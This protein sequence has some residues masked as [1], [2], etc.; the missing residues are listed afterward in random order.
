[1]LSPTTLDS[2]DLSIT[3]V[4]KKPRPELLAPAGEWEALKAAVANGAD[5][6][7][8]GLSDFNARH[9][10]TNFSV[11]ELPTVMRYLHDHNVRGYVTCNTLIFSDELPQ[12]AEYVKSLAQAGVD[13]VI[14]QD[15]GLVRLIRRL[16]PGLTVHGSTQMTLS[17]AR[18]VEFLKELGVERVIL[19]RELSV[20]EIGKIS[21]GTELPLEVF[22][23]GALCVAYSGQCLTSESLGGRSANRGQCA[24]AC[25][26]PYDLIVDGEQRDMGELAYLLSPQDLAA[27]DLIDDMV[28]LGVSCF[29]IEG[30]LK[31]AQYVAATTQAYRAA[32][33]AALANQPFELSREQALAMQQSF[34]RGFTHGFLS[35][36][37]HQELVHGRFPKSRGVKLGKVVSRSA[38]GVVV[39]LEPA[40]LSH[41]PENS[42]H[43]DLP[44]KP[45]DGV[46]F[47]EGHPDQDE[48]GG[49][50]IEV[51]PPSSSR[52]TVRVELAFRSGDL[53]L[54][55]LAIGCLVWKTDDPA[56]RRRL[57]QSF[58]REGVRH[59][60]L[61]DASVFAAVGQPLQIAFRDDQGH[62][63][64]AI[65][66]VVLDT[67][68]KQP[69]RHEVLKEQLGRLGDTPFELGSVQLSTTTGIVPENETV[70]A[71]VPKSLLNELRRKAIDDLRTKREAAERRGEIHEMALAEMRAEIDA[72]KSAPRVIEQNVV[73]ASV[74]SSLHLNIAD[75][76]VG[77]ANTDS[78]NLT[79]LVRSLDQLHAVLDWK[80]D[81]GCPAV[82]LIHCDFEDVRRYETAV[83]LCKAA[84][85]PVALATLRIVKPKEDGWLRQIGSY[86]PDFILV[87]NLSALRYFQERFPQL[88]LLGDYTLNVSNELT[89]AMF[90]EQGLE[91]LVPSYD[92]NWQQLTALLGRFK[93]DQFESVVH[94]HMPMFHMEHCVFAHTLSNGKDYR[95][96]GRPCDNH[97]VD[98]KDRVGESHPLLA[99]VGCRNTLFNAHAQSAAEYIPRMLQLG[100]RWFRVELLRETA[101]EAQQLLNRYS[102][103]LAGKEEARV[104]WNQLRVL[105]QLGVTRGPLDFE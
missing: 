38:V 102:R 37:N 86:A 69:L 45:G 98:L 15:L 100:L 20:D 21:E 91:R 12:I 5:A 47:D 28:K 67:A 79:V 36:V 44:I 76:S 78:P 17:D 57:D 31:S 27:P 72:W 95:D 81:A 85:Q 56:L 52:G 11:E 105:N 48:Q 39:E 73:S 96:C 34:S 101:A 22:I 35:G 97:Q 64:Q 18:G 65:S 10:A 68:L 3:S 25:R 54:A 32:L 16:A 83:E 66:S 53:N 46:V 13:A 103:V 75:V 87:R 88:R 74:E 14:V 93:P 42:R 82:S 90:A 70:P 80:A 6:V 4:V 58:N 71:M 59:R 9:R 60:A 41:L 26:L 62:I 30:R 55:S 19:A 24:Q 40:L 33:D 49:R 2:A 7:Y 51:R 94:Q 84:N 99:D 8:F 43:L 63:G 77:D 92:L 1:M 23:H 61:I 104:T 50:V 29:K 89:A